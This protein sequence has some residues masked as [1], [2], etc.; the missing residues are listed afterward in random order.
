MTHMTLVRLLRSHFVLSVALATA[1]IGCSRSDNATGGTSGNSHLGGAGV[2]SAAAGANE[3]AS[4]GGSA[5]A[6][7]AAGGSGT[8]AVSGSSGAIGGSQVSAGG[9]GSAGV[10]ANADAGGLAGSSGGAGASGSTGAGGGGSGGSAG[11]TSAPPGD[12]AAAAGT[13]L[14]AAHS[15]TRALYAAYS[16]NLFQVRRASDGKNQDIGVA[17][18]GGSVDTDGLSKFCSGTSCSVSMLYDQSGNANHLPQANAANQPVIQYWPTSDGT[19]L[20]MA[21]TVNK[22]WLRNRTKTHKIPVGAESQTEY[23]V[24]HGSHFNSGCCYDYGNMETN[25]RDDGPGTMS[26]LYFGSSTAWT[27]GAGKGPWGMTDYENGLF[28]GAVKDPGG[29][30]ANYPSLVYP[31]NNL[32]MVLTKSN[33]TTAWTLK[34]GNAATG[35]LNTYWKGSLPAA[36]TAPYSPLRQQ[37]GLSLGEGGDGS[38]SGTGAFSEG[39]VIAAVT[40][41]A[42]DDLIQ[43]NISSVY[44]R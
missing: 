4:T 38:N 15:M 34:A 31:G 13:P 8:A 44:G 25:I 36:T 7:A 16:G 28:S 41:D 22:Q 27:K 32:V 10:R 14:V 5:G 11:T 43:A 24:V 1:F 40:S 29:T 20:P 2:A 17:T 30:N 35:P 37:G 19:Q 12:I 18:A 21:V 23:W 6:F 9:Q 33:G 42:T 39:V 3:I 26:A